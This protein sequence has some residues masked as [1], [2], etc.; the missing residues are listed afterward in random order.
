MTSPRQ[1]NIPNRAS[2]AEARKVEETLRLIAAL[3]APDGLATRIQARLN[4]APRRGFLS[5]WSSF[6]LNGWMYNPALRG[7]AAAAIVLIV[8]G[9][10]WAIYSRVQPAPTAKV[11]EMP[12]RVG[13]GG[14]FAIGGA[15][16]TPDTLKGP[17]LVHPAVP[18][19]QN[20]IAPMSSPQVQPPVP[21]AT[22]KKKAAASSV[23]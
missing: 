3:P 20:V 6:G 18:T 1:N 21:R 23:R 15:M 9:G 12:T 5:R 19:Q 14:S 8:A 7:C 11:I 2:G 4:S 17:V 13:N 22:Q 10:G 16:H